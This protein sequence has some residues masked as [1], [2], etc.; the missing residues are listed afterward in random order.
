M[1]NIFESKS[2]Y[3]ATNIEEIRNK[4]KEFGICYVPDVLT[5]EERLE[6][7]SGTWDFFEH[8]TQNDE[9]NIRRERPDTWSNLASLCPGN[10]MLYHHWNAGHSQ[11]SW[12]VRQNPK[13]C[14]IFADL[15]L[16]DVTNLLT[17]FD[18]FA[19]LLPPEITGEGWYTPGSE[20]YHLDQSLTRSYFDGVQGFVTAYDI[21]KGDATL[22]FYEK[23]HKFIGDFIEKFG[24]RVTSDWCKF[25]TE[26][27][28][29]FDDNCTEEQMICPAKSLVL[30]DSRLVH[31]GL[32]PKRSR[33]IEN[34]RCITYISYS[35]KQ[36]ID[37]EK[38]KEKIYG[39]EHMLTSNHYAHNPSFFSTL[40]TN[41]NIITD[42]VVPIDPP[43][44]SQLGKSLVGYNISG[45]SIDPEED[46]L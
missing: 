44:L 46:L 43:I 21:N 13:I 36:R 12:T 31:C 38:L 30:W 5:D 23:S 45:L 14:Q 19:F 40:P 35:P 37:E 6:M 26:E 8:L 24:I 39:Y 41:H 2:K 16:C 9:E 20:W 18:G 28:N 4:I 42:Y 10:D 29:F 22:S 1:G 34:T 11:H 15:F 7:I 25:T 3:E 32:K 27:V 17:S 33:T